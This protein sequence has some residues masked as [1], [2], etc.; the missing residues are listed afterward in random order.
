LPKSNHFYPIF[1]Q[2]LPILLK[3]FLL[4]AG[5][6]ATSTAPAALDHSLS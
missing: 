1:S 5:D 6:A 4:G 2:I 3:K